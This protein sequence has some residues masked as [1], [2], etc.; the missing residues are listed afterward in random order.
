MDKIKIEK[1]KSFR[2]AYILHIGD[3]G[4]VPYDK[5]VPRLFEWAKEKKVRPGF[6]NI[7]VCH[8]NPEEVDPSKCRTWVGIPIKGE[9]NSD[10][11]VKITDI[12][13]MD[14]IALKHKGPASEYKNSY[15]KIQEWMNENGYE[16]AGPSYEV[17]SKKP[18]MV[19]GEMHIFSTI[20]VPIKKKLK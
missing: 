1:I 3:Y 7:N 4:K 14:V 6:K 20:K 13:E 8:D 19:N 18:K 9:I 5:Y 11:E 17:C 2:L 16:W 10:N 15:M 12:S